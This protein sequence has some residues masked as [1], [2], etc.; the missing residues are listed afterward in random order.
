MSSAIP[1]LSY[2]VSIGIRSSVQMPENITVT[3]KRKSFWARRPAGGYHGWDWCYPGG[4]QHTSLMVQKHNEVAQYLGKSPWVPDHMVERFRDLTMAADTCLQVYTVPNLTHTERSRLIAQA[5]KEA[6]AIGSK[7][8]KLLDTLIEEA[9][10]E[11]ASDNYAV[12][13]QR[14]KALRTATSEDDRE[15]AELDSS[16]QHH[17]RSTRVSEEDFS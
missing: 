14:F 9:V 16:Y 12:M 8:A 2:N 4:S 15:Y 10:R 5:N 17:M 3:P 7:L 13:Q 1:A 11:Q 6:Q